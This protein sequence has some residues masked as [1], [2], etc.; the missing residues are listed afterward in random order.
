MKGLEKKSVFFVMY[1]LPQPCQWI[2][3]VTTVFHLQ[4][5]CGVF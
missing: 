3:V 1:G 5:L 4:V 2:Y